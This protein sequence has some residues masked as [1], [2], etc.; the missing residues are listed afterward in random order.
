VPP[1]AVRQIGLGLVFSVRAGGSPLS[2]AARW[3]GGQ[4]PACESD[5]DA[6][7]RSIEIWSAS[8]ITACRWVGSK[9]RNSTRSRLCEAIEGNARSVG[10]LLLSGV[11]DGVPPCFS[12]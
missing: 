3:R 4:V 7:I 10:G 6:R 8:K 1:A 11:D 5:G 9:D 12:A 2:K